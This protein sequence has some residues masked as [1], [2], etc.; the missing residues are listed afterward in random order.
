MEL[1]RKL[2]VEQWF[3][4]QLTK[5]RLSATMFHSL[6]FS[7]L[8]LACLSTLNSSPLH[9]LQSISGTILLHCSKCSF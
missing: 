5:R 6:V 2:N 1:T 3:E 4:Q 7:I 9:P 8:F